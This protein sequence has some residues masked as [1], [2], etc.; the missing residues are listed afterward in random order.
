MDI[1]YGIA[2]SNK[3][4]FLN[5][6]E[7]DPYE[8]LKQQEE[9]KLK[10]KDE[11]DKKAKNKHAKKSAPPVDAKNKQAETTVTKKEDK[12]NSARPERGGRG[13]RQNREPREIRDNETDRRPPRRQPPRE[14]REPK[15]DENV[16]PEFRERPE[17][18]TGFNREGGER[19]RGR[20]G[21]G[22]FG[23]GRG[24]RGN[25]GGPREG[26]REGGGGG[27][28]APGGGPGGERPRRDFDRHSGSDKTGIKAVEKK[29]GGGA[30][31]WGTFKDDM[32]EPVQDGEEEH[33]ENWTSEEVPE[34]AE[35]N[36]SGEAEHVGDGEEPAKQMTLDEWKALQKQNRTKV[37]YNIRK[38][39]EGEDN[40]KWKKGV[41]Y[42]KKKEE[43][44]DEEDEDDED[45]RH[46]K[47]DLLDIRIT[48]NESPRRG[49]GGRRPRDGRSRGGRG[50]GG[51]MGRGD[52]KPRETAPKMDDETDFPSLV[53]SAA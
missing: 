5:D 15:G 18:S 53:K 20:G 42:T 29:E 22:G 52:R 46:K 36:E 9:A 11:T 14:P 45:D 8:I 21:R 34:N 31:N 35:L 3:Y 30:R 32:V 25:R 27:F 44:D 4:Q 7:E 40:N 19:G 38:A 51:G 2:V 23:R 43:S 41:A 33:R 39:G 24:G 47:K 12:P 1:Q 17:G 6:E 37:D 13:G 49:R 26:F 48:F 16:P 10:K 28:G 50:G